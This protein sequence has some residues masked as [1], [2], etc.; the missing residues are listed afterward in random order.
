MDGAM[1]LLHAHE[2]SDDVEAQLRDAYPNAEIIIHQDPAG[3]EEPRQAFPPRS[4]AG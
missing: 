4:Q 1:N 2:I 3:L